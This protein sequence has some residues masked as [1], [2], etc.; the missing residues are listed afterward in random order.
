MH[1]SVGRY[2]AGRE[3]QIERVC[4]KRCVKEGP[5]E[6]QILAGKLMKLFEDLAL[7][8][9]PDTMGVRYYIILVPRRGNG[10]QRRGARAGP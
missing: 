1:V 10:A 7:S 4:V 6:H 9:T 2:D 5:Q 3:R 8:R